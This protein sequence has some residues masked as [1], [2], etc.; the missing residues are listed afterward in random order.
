MW[1]LME[2]D[3]KTTTHVWNSCNCCQCTQVIQGGELGHIEPRVWQIYI[4]LLT[5]QPWAQTMPH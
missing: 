3:L 1:I 2:N 5:P 4:E